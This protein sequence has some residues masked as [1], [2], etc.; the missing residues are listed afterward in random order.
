MTTNNN[1]YNQTFV[2]KYSWRIEKYNGNIVL[3]EYM[4][5]FDWQGFD[6][7]YF[8]NGI[9]K[10]G[11]N[12]QGI[13]FANDLKFN[14]NIDITNLIPFQL[15]T[16]HFDLRKNVD[17]LYSYSIGFRSPEIA[18]VTNSQVAQTTTSDTSHISSNLSNTDLEDK[19]GTCQEKYFIRI[20]AHALL[21]EAYKNG[22]K[23]IIPLGGV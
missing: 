3:S 11:I 22:D 7:I 12:S 17:S 14:F 10:I 8:T 16:N 4:H 23:K 21:F 15:K 9:N 13:F 5:P 20:L 2:K 6:K 19:Q 1:F 18:V